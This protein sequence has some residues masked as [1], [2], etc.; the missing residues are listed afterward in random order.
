MKVSQIKEQFNILNIKEY[1]KFIE[2]YQAD[3]RSGVQKIVTTAQNKLAKQQKIFDRYYTLV[4]F[5]AENSTDFL[6]VGVDEAGRGPLFGPVVAGAVAIKPCDE[7]Y[8][9]YDSK[10]I[11][12]EKR[13][14]L[15]QKIIE[16]ADSYGVGVVS[17]EEI[18]KIG[19]LNA[20]KKAMQI[21]VSQLKVDYTTV[22]VD[23]V[24]IKFKDKVTKAI[25]KGDAKSFSIAAAS[26]IAKVTRDRIV[27]ELSKDL[28]DYDLLNNKG[29][30]TKKHYQ[31]LDRYGLSKQH[32]K[33][34][35]KDF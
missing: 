1:D 18:D 8:E 20:T 33:S 19:I 29:Y 5:D 32:R 34:F 16:R 28:P 35:L 3:E 24:D 26:I 25:V 7:L 15:Y 23:Y 31:A 13:E 22:L 2:T 9:V 14:F 6:V 30:G 21:A 12:E 4:K 11:K 17:A 27:T 10:T